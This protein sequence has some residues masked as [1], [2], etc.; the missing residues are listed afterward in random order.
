MTDYRISELAEIVGLPPTTL[1]FYDR[2]GL[3]LLTSYSLTRVGMRPRARQ[4][5]VTSTQVGRS[6]SV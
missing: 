2:L 4:S 6:R 5:S 3:L 1:R